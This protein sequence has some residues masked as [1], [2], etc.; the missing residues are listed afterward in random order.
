MAKGANAAKSAADDI[1]VLGRGTPS[2]LQRYADTLGG[3][4]INNAELANNPKALFKHIHSEMRKSDQIVQIIDDIPVN[5]VIGRGSGQWARAEKIFLDQNAAK[6]EGKL[7]RV[8]R[9]DLLN[10]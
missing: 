2:Q 3:R 1:L 4:V 9:E 5:R 10:P 8:T 7:R 6:F